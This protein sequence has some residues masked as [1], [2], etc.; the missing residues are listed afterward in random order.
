M[1]KNL[2]PRLG[3][4]KASG[5]SLYEQA[6]YAPNTEA[7]STICSSYSSVQRDYLAKFDDGELYRSFSNLQDLTTFSQG[8]ESQMAAAV[9]NNV[10]SVEQQKMLT[11]VLLTQRSSFLKR[12]AAA[13]SCTQPVPLYV[14][15]HLA[16][17]I[18]SA[19]PYQPSVTFL[20]GTLQM[21]ATVRSRT[22]GSITRRVLLS[23]EPQTP[24]SCCAYAKS[25]SGFH[26]FHGVA[27]L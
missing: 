10:R 3:A 22:D 24:P 1:K 14:E 13:I 18:S 27:V 2:G 23:D 20:L 7:V 19:R 15:K 5:L 11:T 17:L 8:A 9:R 4:D 26:C 25:G 21:E 6:V 12:Q 16:Q